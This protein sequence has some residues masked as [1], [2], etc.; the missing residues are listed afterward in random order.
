[1]QLSLKFQNAKVNNRNSCG[2][3]L[4]VSKSFHGNVCSEVL[5]KV[6]AC[7]HGISSVPKVVAKSLNIFEE[8]QDLEDYRR[9]ALPKIISVS[10]FLSRCSEGG[11]RNPI[12]SKM[13]LYATVVDR[14]KLLSIF[15]KLRSFKQQGSWIHLCNLVQFASGN[16]SSSW[17]NLVLKLCKYLEKHLCGLPSNEDV[18][19]GYFRN[20]R[21]NFSQEHS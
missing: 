4:Y 20:F 10:C 12:R 1:M 16:W 11:F 13:E 3:V 6:V 2:I 9:S 21:N 7:Q 14:W 15:A 8:F 19:L 5:S 17:E 18:L